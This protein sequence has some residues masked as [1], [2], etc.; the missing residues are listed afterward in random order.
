[1]EKHSKRKGMIRTRVLFVVLIAA[2]IVSGCKKTIQQPVQSKPQLA[3]IEQVRSGGSPYYWV[4]EF[5][6]QEG[7]RISQIKSYGTN[8]DLTIQR[9]DYSDRKLDYSYFLNGTEQSSSRLVYSINQA[10]LIADV[11]STYFKYKLEYIYNA[12]GFLTR[13]NYFKGVVPEGHIS[14]SYGPQDR[15]DSLTFY[16]V[17]NKVSYVSVFAYASSQTNTIGK[18]N[19]GQGMFGTDQQ[20]PLIRETRIVYNHPAAMGIRTKF[21]EI[22]YNYTYDEKGLIRTST[23]NRIDYAIP[24]GNSV[25]YEVGSYRYNYK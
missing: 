25:Y 17:D 11:T 21:F 2:I 23:A 3:S 10:G 12:K 5:I 8:T 22:E 9:Y 1:M 4:E 20:R 6:Y 16:D 18:E 13:T 7:G 19:K 24:G 14:Y 15:L